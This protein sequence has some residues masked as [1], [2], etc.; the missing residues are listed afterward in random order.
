MNDTN[1]SRRAALVGMSRVVGAAWLA[2]NWPA[3]ARAAEHSHHMM[4]APAAARI[5]HLDA[6]E[7]QVATLVS[8]HIVPG[9]DSPGA[10]E[11][12]VIYFIDY[13]VGQHCLGADEGF[14][15]GL[16]ALDDSAREL[17]PDAGGFAALD[18]VRQL[19]LGTRSSARRSSA[20]CTRSPSWACSHPRPTAA[21]AT[22][23]AGS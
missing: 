8:G 7:E 11:A 5:L 1:D 23:P 3:V 16:K 18:E 17:Y 6:L 2:A 9:G 22:A 13:C 14:C 20:S 19:E 21:T 4:A 15:K 12:G 10:R